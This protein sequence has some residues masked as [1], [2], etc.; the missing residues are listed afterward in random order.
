MIE[1]LMNYDG[2][3]VL[4]GY[5]SRLYE[6]LVKDGW[7]RIDIDLV[8][9][10]AGRTRA[11]GLQGTGIAKKKQLRVECIWRNPEAMRRIAKK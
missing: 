3:V 2:A 7:N 6:P 10:A 5:N 8:C 4:S 9:S 1:K 11:S